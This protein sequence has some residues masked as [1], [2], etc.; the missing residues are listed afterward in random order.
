MDSSTR[1]VCGGFILLI[2]L[3][4]KHYLSGPFFGVRLRLDPDYPNEPRFRGN[5]IVD[6]VFEYRLYGLFVPWCAFLALV[7]PNYLLCAFTI[8]WTIL[9]WKRTFYYTTPFRFWTRAYAE[10]PSKHRN[11]IRYAEE[12]SREIERKEKAGVRWDSPEIQE[13]I[14]T[15]FKLQEMIIKGEQN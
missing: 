6:S 3:N 2:W 9:T 4:L 14:T 11:R 12:I 15:G 13:L 8:A 5:L 7:L 10:S 1:G